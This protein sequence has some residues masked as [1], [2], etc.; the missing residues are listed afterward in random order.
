[1]DRRTLLE[2]ELRM[3]F[4]GLEVVRFSL[5]KRNGIGAIEFSNAIKYIK[6]NNLFQDARDSLF[7]KDFHGDSISYE[8]KYGNKNQELF[9]EVGLDSIGDKIIGNIQ[10]L[11]KKGNK[12]NEVRMYGMSLDRLYGAK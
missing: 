5:E 4:Q 6:E 2:N 9:F 3:A 7:S 11:D 1:M 10:S 8:L 12:I